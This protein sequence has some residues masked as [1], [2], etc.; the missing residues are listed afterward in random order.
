MRSHK[1]ILYDFRMIEIKRINLVTTNILNK[2]LIGVGNG[3][4]R[5]PKNNILMKTTGTLAKK[6]LQYF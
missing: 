5:T 2:K 6:P 3:K 1:L 4:V